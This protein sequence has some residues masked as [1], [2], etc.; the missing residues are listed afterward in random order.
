MQ[1]IGKNYRPHENVAERERYED[2]E[3]ISCDEPKGRPCSNF[4]PLA[5][6]APE[7]IRRIFD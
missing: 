1:P 5:A 6:S 7:A 3:R 2:R 4:G